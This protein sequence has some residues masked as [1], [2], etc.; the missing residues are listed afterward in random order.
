MRHARIDRFRSAV[1][2]SVVATCLALGGCSSAS[3]AFATVPASPSSVPGCTFAQ[4]SAS[5]SGGVVGLDLAP[6]DATAVWWPGH[7]AHP[8]N[9]VVAAISSAEATRLVDAVNHAPQ[10]SS[11]PVNCP[12][13]QGIGVSIYF[14][15]AHGQPELINVTLDGCPSVAAPGR[16][17]RTLDVTLRQELAGVAPSAFRTYLAR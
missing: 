8:C 13:M 10:T 3:P 9:P 7:N 17:A 4:S 15:Y 2:L 16:K 5:A 14:D 11:D 12:A 6:R 1:G